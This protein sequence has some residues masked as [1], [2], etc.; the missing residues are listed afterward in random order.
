MLS[1]SEYSDAWPEDN[2]SIFVK[3]SRIVKSFPSISHIS[4][5]LELT[6]SDSEMESI[7]L[8]QLLI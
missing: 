8:N 1:L 3:A 7:A 4:F 5:S 6:C 2:E